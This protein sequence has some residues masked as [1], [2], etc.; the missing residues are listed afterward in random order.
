MNIVT[1]IEYLNKTYGYNLDGS[2]YKDIGDWNDWWKGKYKPFHVYHE[3]DYNGKKIERDMYSLR[4]A[5]KVCEDWASML[6]NEKVRIE[7]ED[8]HSQEFICGPDDEE[9]GVLFENKFEIKGN[10]LIEKAF[11]TGTGAFVLHI[12]NMQADGE[13]GNVVK[14][15]ESKIRIEYLTADHIIPLSVSGGEITEVAFASEVLQGGKDFIYVEM[16]LLEPNGYRVINSYFE[17][18]E[19]QLKP[20]P[21]PPGVAES[22]TTGSSVPLF[23]IIKPNICNNIQDTSLGVSIFANA[24][25]NLKGVDLAFH[26]FLRDFKLGGKKVFVNDSLTKTDQHGNTVTPDD[27]AQQLFVTIGDDFVKDEKTLIYEHNPSLRVQENIDGV[28]AQLD[29]LSFRCGLGAKYYRFNAGGTVVT[30]TQY[31]GEKQDLMKNI[32]KQYIMLN[33]ALKQLLKSLLWVG[34]EIAGLPVDPETKI[35]IKFDDSFISDKDSER[36]NDLQEVRDEI[37]N[38]WEYRMKWYGEDEETAKERVTREDGGTW[39]EE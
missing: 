22:F 16:H 15:P 13:S 8:K 36:A 30:A 26:N 11:A 38:K 3:K 10:E 25:D 31:V 37:M 39:F 19:G 17:E 34:K 24:I 21:L 27:V 4:M 9:G 23:S 20:A 6:L 33:T 29:Y 14:S 2:Y 5:K 1:V 32:N 7:I 18:E 12:Q 28:Q 35:N